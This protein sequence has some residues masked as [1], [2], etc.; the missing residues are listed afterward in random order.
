M[1]TKSYK[2]KISSLHEEIKELLSEAIGLEPDEINESSHIDNVSGW[3]SMAH[4]KLVIGIESRYGAQLSPNEI[5]GIL[6]YQSL[7][8]F[9]NKLVN[10]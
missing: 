8:D 5:Q 10:K 7:Y 4:L 9:V 1:L 6:N 3:D 2:F